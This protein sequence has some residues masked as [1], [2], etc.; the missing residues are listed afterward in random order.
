MFN[1]SR[2]AYIADICYARKCHSVNKTLIFQNVIISMS[3]RDEYRKFLRYHCE[4]Y[5][6]PLILMIVLP[7]RQ[8]AC[9]IQ[10]SPKQLSSGTDVSKLSSCPVVRVITLGLNISYI[11]EKSFAR[12]TDINYSGSFKGNTFCQAV[13]V[14]HIFTYFV[15]IS[16]IFPAIFYENNSALFD[17]FDKI[18]YFIL[19]EFLYSCLQKD[20]CKNNIIIID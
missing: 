14:R 3:F 17:D 12:F 5:R 16:R 18:F 2:Y 6:V 4:L 20:L 19:F 10:W 1:T 15:L 9:V 13:N 11:L 7:K 8:N